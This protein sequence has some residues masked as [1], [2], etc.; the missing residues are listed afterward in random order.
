[1]AAALF[2]RRA[3]EIILSTHEG[4][5]EELL[6]ASRNEVRHSRGRGEQ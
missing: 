6:R 2:A 1:M 4:L 5:A 3:F